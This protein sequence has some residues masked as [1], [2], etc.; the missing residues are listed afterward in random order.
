[1]SNYRCHCWCLVVIVGV[2]DSAPW[3]R[4]YHR[5]CFV[6]VSVS[7]LSEAAYLLVAASVGFCASFPLS[8]SSSL[9]LSSLEASFCC[10]LWQILL[11]LL[12]SLGVL[13][14]AVSRCCCCCRRRIVVVVVVFGGVLSLSS[15]MASRRSMKR[16]VYIRLNMHETTMELQ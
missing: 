1:M 8:S 2:S 13:L 16:L 6:V 9:G 15:S 14:L 3:H 10:F 5:C 7:S 4:S 11:P 12:S